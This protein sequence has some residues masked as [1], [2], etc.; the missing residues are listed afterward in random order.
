MKSSDY[1]M[2]LRTKSITTPE[3]SSS[4]RKNITKCKSRCMIQIKYSK[5]IST[6]LFTLNEIVKWILNREKIIN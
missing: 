3:I 5:S 4:I 6:F 1:K 2:K